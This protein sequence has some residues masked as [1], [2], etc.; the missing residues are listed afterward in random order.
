MRSEAGSNRFLWS[1]CTSLPDYMASHSRRQQFITMR[2]SDLKISCTLEELI[3]MQLKLIRLLGFLYHLGAD[4]TA[5]ILEVNAAFIFRSKC[6]QWVRFFVYTT[7][8]FEQ[9]WEGRLRLVPHLSY[10]EQ[11][12]GK[13]QPLTHPT[14]SDPANRSSMYFQNT[15]KHC[16]HPHSVNTL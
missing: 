11:Q 10:Y 1:V 13:D 16:P 2:T 14:H 6:V 5:D 8:P 9:I 7:F 15:D 3:K 12:A 4:S